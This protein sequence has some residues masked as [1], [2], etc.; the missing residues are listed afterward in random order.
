MK[1]ILDTL[2]KYAIPYTQIKE[3]FIEVDN[4]HIPIIL[5]LQYIITKSGSIT[6]YHLSNRLVFNHNEEHFTI[7][8]K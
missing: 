8:V 5:W 6:M 1:H 7:C 2:K 4:T 3:H